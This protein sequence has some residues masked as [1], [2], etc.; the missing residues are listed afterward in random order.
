MLCKYIIVYS[1]FW[2]VLDLRDIFLSRPG[3]AIFAIF[4][5]G[6]RVFHGVDCAN[7]SDGLRFR[8]N[9]LQRFVLVS[10]LHMFGLAGVLLCRVLRTQMYTVHIM[11]TRLLN[12]W[13][14]LLVYLKQKHL[15]KALGGLRLDL[16]LRVFNCTERMPWCKETGSPVVTILSLDFLKSLIS[17]SLCH[18][19][20]QSLQSFKICPSN[21]L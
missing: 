20:L 6:C 12:A 3:P 1:I 9:C 11:W 5:S 7:P 10:S 15:A 14:W 19:F 18:S 8:R 16:T 21:Q 17:F 13:N 4:A 2:I